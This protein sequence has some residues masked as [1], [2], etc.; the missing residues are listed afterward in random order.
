MY[1]Y[2]YV[3][4]PVTIHYRSYV[5]LKY[6]LNKLINKQQN[7]LLISSSTKKRNNIHSMQI[8]QTQYLVVL[9]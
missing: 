8:G 6:F 3:R 1:M 9:K 7:D 4:K 5:T 2:M